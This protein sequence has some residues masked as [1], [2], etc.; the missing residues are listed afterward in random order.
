MRTP[1]LCLLAFVPAVAAPVPRG[2]KRHADAACLEGLWEIV[3]QDGG[4]GHGTTEERFW[5]RVADGKMSIGQDQPTAKADSP[6]TLDPTT[7]PRQLD[8]TWR[9]FTTPQRY[10][11]HLDGDT[12][13]WCHAPDDQPRPTEFKGGGGA[14]CTIWKRVKE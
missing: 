8:L 4:G 13:T 10:I 1:L 11:Y 14:F 7:T 2:I 5:L 12:L 9:N 6:F 3:T